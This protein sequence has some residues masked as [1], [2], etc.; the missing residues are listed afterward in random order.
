MVCCACVR[1]TGDMFGRHGMR[2]VLLAKFVPGLSTVMPPLA[3]MFGV[4]TGPFILFDGMGSLLYGGCF[5]LIGLL[6]SNQLEQAGQ[7]MAGL[8]RGALILTLALVGGYVSFKF[9]RRQHL[10]RQLRIARISVEELRQRQEAQEAPL[11]IDLRAASDLELD[12][13]MIPGALHIAVEDVETR[14]HE[15]PRDREVIVYCNCPNEV[16]SAR[17]ALLLHRKGITRVRPLLGGI[18]AWREKNY[19]IEMFSAAARS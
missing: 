4:R 19:P 2:G 9:L 3:G 8:G 7:L 12:P 17:V 5:I 14:H 15:I 11:V 16:T 10:L 13:A 1:R 18:E 6:F